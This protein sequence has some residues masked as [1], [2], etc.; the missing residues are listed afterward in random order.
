MADTDPEIKAVLR[1]LTSAVRKLTAEL[2]SGREK[3]VRTRRVKALRR[4]RQVAEL[5]VS[6]LAAAAA[7]RALAR[8]RG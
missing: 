5:P 1:E 7:R 4:A 2:R 6:D 8:T 3:S